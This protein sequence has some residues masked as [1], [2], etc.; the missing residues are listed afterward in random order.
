MCYRK[1]QESPAEIKR[2]TI[3]RTR[4]LQNAESIEIRNTE[5]EIEKRAILEVEVKGVAE[6]MVVKVTG[7]ET[8]IGKAEIEAEIEAEIGAET[9]VESEIGNFSI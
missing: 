7:A 4:S 2:G 3:I 9:G 1:W 8:E 5:M 6:I